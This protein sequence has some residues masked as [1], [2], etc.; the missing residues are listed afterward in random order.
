M[1]LRI[2]ETT[3]TGDAV[4]T[5]I[6]SQDGKRVDIIVRNDLPFMCLVASIT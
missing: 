2:T 6:A 1:D 4:A 3:D 5:Y